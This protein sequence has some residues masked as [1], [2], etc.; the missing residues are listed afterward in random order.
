MPDKHIATIPKNSTEEIRITLG[1]YKGHELFNARV[2]F[3]GEDGTMR[4]GKAGIAF[5]LDKLPAFA[6]AVA[7]ALKEAGGANG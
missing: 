6:E 1:S 7:A 4:P 2:W 5:K 3:E